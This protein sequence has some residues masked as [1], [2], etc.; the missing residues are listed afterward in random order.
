M[1]RREPKAIEDMAEY[2][3]NEVLGCIDEPFTDHDKVQC[4]LFALLYIGL[5]LDAIDSRLMHMETLMR[6]IYDQ[7]QDKERSWNTIISEINQRWR[8]RHAD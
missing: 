6:G 7:S 3:M 1:A 4:Q 8:E 5:M 2:W